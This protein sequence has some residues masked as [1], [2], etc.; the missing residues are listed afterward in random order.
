VKSRHLE[1]GLEFEQV[2]GVDDKDVVAMRN[3]KLQC[4]VSIVS[5]VL[6]GSLMQL[7]GQIRHQCADRV[8]GPIARAGI[9]DH[10]PIYDGTQ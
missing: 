1:S 8:L 3:C 7:A 4:L 10:P 2:I 5:E 6:P 9:D